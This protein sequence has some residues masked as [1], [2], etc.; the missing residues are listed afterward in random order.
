MIRRE[1]W[2]LAFF[3]YTERKGLPSTEAS[4]AVFTDFHKTGPID[5]DQYYWRGT[6][7]NRAYGT[8]ENLYFSPFL[9][10]IFGPINCGPP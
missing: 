2:W 10:T 1:W 5:N 4:G 6:T 7:V 9:L 3:L 8:H